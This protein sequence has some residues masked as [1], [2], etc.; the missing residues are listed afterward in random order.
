MNVNFKVNTVPLALA[1]A[2]ALGDWVF[3][4]SHAGD[5]PSLFQRIDSPSASASINDVPTGSYTATAQRFDTGGN[6]FGL[7]V[8][9]SF[10]VPEPEVATDPTPS[11]TSSTDTGNTEAPDAGSPTPTPAVATGEAAGSLT[12]TLS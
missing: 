3:V 4:V 11:P 10:E 12:V 7:Q 2:Q 6:A 5:S 8:T 9:A 1:V